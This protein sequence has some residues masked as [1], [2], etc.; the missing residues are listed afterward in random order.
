M[1]LNIIRDVEICDPT[2]ILIFSGETPEEIKDY[3]DGYMMSSEITV[4][5]GL[6]SEQS[7][8]TCWGD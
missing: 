1:A 6:L 4:G 5:V 2:V 8:G 3:T 7:S